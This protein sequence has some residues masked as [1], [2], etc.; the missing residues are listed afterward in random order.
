MRMAGI[1]AGGA[2][3]LGQCVYNNIPV[4]YSLSVSIGRGEVLGGKGGVGGGEGDTCVRQTRGYSHLVF[5]SCES[6][7]NVDMNSGISIG[8]KH[9]LEQPTGGWS[10]ERNYPPVILWPQLTSD[11]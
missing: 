8:A 1:P 4:G 10:E 9:R 3:R 6:R 11:E 7:R 5:M 2:G